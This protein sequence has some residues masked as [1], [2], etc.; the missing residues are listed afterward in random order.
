MF[1]VCMCGMECR[2]ELWRAGAVTTVGGCQGRSCKW[3]SCE[4]QA[5]QKLRMHPAVTMHLAA[6]VCRG[7]STSAW[8][9]WRGAWAR[10]TSKIMCCVGRCYARAVGGCLACAEVMRRCRVSSPDARAERCPVRATQ[11]T[12]TWRGFGCAGEMWS[13]DA[14]VCARASASGESCSVVGCVHDSVCCD[15]R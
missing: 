7:E 10:A 11:Q 14:I 6:E 2:H 1:V 15:G 5:R 4:G 12:D 8:C 3:Q 9:M 13:A